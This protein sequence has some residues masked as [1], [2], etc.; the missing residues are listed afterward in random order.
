CSRDIARKVTDAAKRVILKRLFIAI[1]ITTTN[2]LSDHVIFEVLIRNTGTV[3]G[4][5]LTLEASR[6]VVVVLPFEMW[7]KPLLLQSSRRP[8]LHRRKD[9]TIDGDTGNASDIVVRNVQ[10]VA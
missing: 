10:I 4:Q 9:L 7:T 5:C 6:V 3:T 2:E 8:I 1:P